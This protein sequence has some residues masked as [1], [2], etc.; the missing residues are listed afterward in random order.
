M[1]Q[2]FK[3]NTKNYRVLTP[4]G[5][6]PF[7]G[8]SMR[9][10]KPLILLEF[11]KGAWI[12]CTFDHKL[13]V[14]SD[15]FRTAEELEPGDTVECVDGSVK[16]ISKTDLGKS[17]SVYDLIEV[18]GGHRYYTN[19][20]L[21]SNCEFLIYD[22]TLINAVKLTELKGR[23]PI[24][25]M[26]QTRWYKE[27]DPRCTYLISLDPSLG[28]GGDNAAIQV[29]ELPALEQVA[30]WRHN[31]TPVQIQIKHLRDIS[32]YIQ[33]RSKE[34]GGTATIYYSVENNSVGE[35]ALICIS[36]IGEENIPGLFLSEPIRKGH[37]RKFRKGFNTTHGTKIAVCSQFKHMIETQKMKI[38]SK[39][40][41]SELKNYVAHGVG[42]GAKRGESDDLISA[43][44]LILRM[45]S[46]LADWDP[47]VYEKMTDKITEDQMPMPIFVSTGF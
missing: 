32:K 11:E 45:S 37:V 14:G 43:T 30:E 19:G 5:F 38:N 40:L 22:E 35:S 29:F 33:D 25:T 27:I 7:A 28:T 39:A 21:S 47:K 36:N 34:K 26:G 8:I 4:S 10:I 23:D 16:L 2:T 18:E 13:Y 20:I 6:Q 3:P 1:D 31:M 17:E 9:G 41:I 12:E 24:M 15:L 44:L 42:Y 46:I